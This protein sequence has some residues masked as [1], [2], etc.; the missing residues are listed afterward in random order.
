MVHGRCRVAVFELRDVAERRNADKPNLLVAIIKAEWDDDFAVYK[1]QQ[2]S[3]IYGRYVLKCR[4]ELTEKILFPSENKAKTYKNE[5]VLKLVK[6]GFTVNPIPDQNMSIYVLELDPTACPEPDKIFLYVG[7]TSLPVEERIRNHLAGEKSSKW[8]QNHY[9]KRRPELEP[10]STY[11]SAWDAVAEETIWGKKLQ[12][13][14]F[15]VVGP[16]GL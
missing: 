9:V 15:Y 6:E 11:S 8:V 7:M 3:E 13:D 16:Q 1:K 4:P 2:K 5:L 12:Q 14:G 10:A